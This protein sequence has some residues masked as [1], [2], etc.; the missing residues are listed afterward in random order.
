MQKI[1]FAKLL[2][3][4]TVTA[5]VTGKLDLGEETISDLDY[6]NYVG[7]YA[8]H[9]PLTPEKRMLDR[10]FRERFAAPPKRTGQPIE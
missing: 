6:S 4:E 8:S 7:L 2:G 9:E 3:V 10:W 5:S 1:D